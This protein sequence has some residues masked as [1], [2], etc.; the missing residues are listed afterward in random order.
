MNC[1][2]RPRCKLW[3][4][5]LELSRW[6]LKRIP[7]HSL[8]TDSLLAAENALRRKQIESDERGVTYRRNAGPT[9]QSLFGNSCHERRTGPSSLFGG[10]N[11]RMRGAARSAA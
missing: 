7:W 6:R 4:D 1:A 8:Q 5:E 11:S 2:I 10:C 3:C 9:E